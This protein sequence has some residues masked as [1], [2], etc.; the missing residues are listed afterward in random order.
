M[1]IRHRIT[2]ELWRQGSP[3]RLPIWA[4]RLMTNVDF[5]PDAMV[6][7]RCLIVHG[8]RAVVGKSA[9]VGRYVASSDSVTLVV[10]SCA[11]GERCSAPVNSMQRS[12]RRSCVN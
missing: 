5:H 11:P 9:G 2:N 6:G 10:I 1:S 12:P 4:L 3:A 7:Q 8:T